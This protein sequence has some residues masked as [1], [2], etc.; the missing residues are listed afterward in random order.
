MSA[1]F[2]TGSIASLDEERHWFIG[3][4]LGMT[5]R[6][7]SYI[8]DVLDYVLK[9]S[10]KQEILILI[11]DELSKYNYHAFEGRSLTHGSAVA[12]AMREGEKYR[13]TISKVLDSYPPEMVAS[14]ITCVMSARKKGLQLRGGRT[15]PT[16]ST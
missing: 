9:H 6:I 7:E 15:S 8:K 5:P 2:R 3:V 11:G 10:K 16:S 4:S 14:F 13:Q 1:D 12:C